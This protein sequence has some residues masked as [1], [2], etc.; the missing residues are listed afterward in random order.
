MTAGI[1]ALFIGYT[2]ASY[3][4]VLMRGYDIPW[5][6]WIDPLDPWQWPAGTPKATPATQVFPS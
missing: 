6:R 3:G 5:K 2:I 1:A 4:V